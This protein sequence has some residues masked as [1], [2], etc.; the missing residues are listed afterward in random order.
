M[1]ITKINDIDYAA[2]PEGALEAIA[3]LD[4]DEDI[5]TEEQIADVYRILNLSKDNT[6]RELR[7]VRN[8]L[9]KGFRP[10]KNAAYDAEDYRGYDRYFNA[11][12]GSTAA[13]DRL[14]WEKDPKAV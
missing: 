12:S 7:A 5:I 2:L 6:V 4:I 8:S 9:V 3:S 10:L 1:D 14:I 13:I 11:M